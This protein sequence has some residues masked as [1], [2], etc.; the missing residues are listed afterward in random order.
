MTHSRFLIEL[1]NELRTARINKLLTQ[2]DVG[3]RVGLTRSAI[4]NYERGK[5]SI[6][7]ELFFKLCEIYGVDE[8]EIIK[9]VKKYLYR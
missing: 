6:E 7:I 2:E 3:N 9:R 8:I 1:G 4:A 5:R